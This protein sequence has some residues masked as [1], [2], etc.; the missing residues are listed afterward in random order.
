MKHLAGFDACRSAFDA[1]VKRD[2]ERE[3]IADLAW[4]FSK[5]RIV[6]QGDLSQISV[7]DIGR[8]RELRQALATP[9]H[10][11]LY[12]SWLATGNLDVESPV[13]DDLRMSGTVIPQIDTQVFLRPPVRS[14]LSKRARS[15]T[16]TSLRLESSTCG[17]PGTV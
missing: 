10:E 9:R 5:R 4:Y 7:Q 1:Y 14:T 17:R 11:G 15:T 16:P 12:A 8:L 6:E 13:H 2:P 3:R